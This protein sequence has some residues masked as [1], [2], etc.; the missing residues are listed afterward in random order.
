MCSGIIQHRDGEIR[1]I[2][3]FVLPDT[4]TDNAVG[5]M[6]ARA[7][8]VGWELR[9]MRVYGDA[10][11]S[12][13]DST[14]GLSDWYIIRNRLRN[15]GAIFRVPPANPRVKDTINAVN[16]KLLA[17]DGTVSI[18]IDPRCKQLIADLGA[19]MAGTDLEPQHAVSWLR[20]FVSREYPVLPVQPQG[21]QIAIVG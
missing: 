15:L 4:K 21:G 5:L 14:S 12:A 3:E 2:D 19:A 10:T 9:D 8:A 18:S 17:A 16:A 7:Q 11:G 13:R 20:Y 6:L 1:V